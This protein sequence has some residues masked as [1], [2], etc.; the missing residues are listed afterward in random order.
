[1]LLLAALPEVRLGH[2]EAAPVTRTIMRTCPY[3][4][5]FEPVTGVAD[6]SIFLAI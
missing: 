6:R 3:Y 5:L 2:V 1:L 4:V